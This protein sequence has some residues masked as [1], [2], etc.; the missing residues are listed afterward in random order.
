MPKLYTKRGD[1]GITD[2]KGERVYKSS[3]VI[4]LLG[5]IDM[6]NSFLGCVD[7]VRAPREDLNMVQHLLFEL[8]AQ[9]SGYAKESVDLVH[10]TKELE[11]RIDRYCKETP[12][13]TNF[14]LPSGPVHLARAQCRRVESV[15]VEYT[16]MKQDVDFSLVLQ[17]I[18]RLSDFLFALARY[19]ALVEILHT[20][21]WQNQ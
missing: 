15:L 20:K 3:K 19:E 9:F 21:S 12:H 14:I 11:K 1:A 17:F 8:G 6:L 13:L 16:Q 7:L 4:H 2:I 5:E 10:Y 18:N